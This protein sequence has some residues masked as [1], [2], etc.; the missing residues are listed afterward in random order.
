MG[1][2]TYFDNILPT[3]IKKVQS[4]QSDEFLQRPAPS[5][6]AAVLNTSENSLLPRSQI[7]NTKLG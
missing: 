4:P 3:H 6:P 2:D 1:N 7:T 5:E